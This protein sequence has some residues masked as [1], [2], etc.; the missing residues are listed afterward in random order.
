MTAST[1][2]T[3]K[4]H[5]ADRFKKNDEIVFRMIAGEAVLV[6]M[7]RQ[8]ADLDAIF[9]LNESAAFAWGLIDGK[10]SLEAIAGQIVA[11]YEVE[12]GE[13]AQDV[14]ELAE[15]LSEIGAIDAV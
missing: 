3:C 6:P 9:A 12:E 1:L 5:L 10:R 4:V 11:E 13:A 14:V 15:K 8:V 7:R 2:G